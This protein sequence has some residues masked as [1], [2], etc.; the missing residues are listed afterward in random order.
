MIEASSVKAPGAGER[1]GQSY[2]RA[3]FRLVGETKTAPKKLVF[4]M[5]TEE[6]PDPESPLLSAVGPDQMTLEGE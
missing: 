4:Q 2:L 6:M 3:G 5:M 1:V